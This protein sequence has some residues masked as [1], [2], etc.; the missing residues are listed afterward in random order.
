MN[1][2]DVAAWQAARRNILL[3]GSSC[4]RPAG[5]EL[6]WS[7]CTKPPLSVG[8]Q[9]HA[10]CV[11]GGM[12]LHLRLAFISLCFAAG[13]NVGVRP[14]CMHHGLW[15]LPGKHPS[16]LQGQ[17]RGLPPCT[18]ISLA[19]AGPSIWCSVVLFVPPGAGGSP[20]SA[21]GQCL[22]AFC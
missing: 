16:G 17:S 3:G 15:Q 8:A 19:A 4:S 6:L 18:I 2:A 12:G 20:G 1:F 21:P 10:A 11:S 22:P 9:P 14:E 5:V 13:H 7:T